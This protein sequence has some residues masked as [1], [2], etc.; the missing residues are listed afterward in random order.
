MRKLALLC[1]F[2][3]MP[4]LLA[5]AQERQIPLVAVLELAGEGVS[6]DELGMV[7]NLL[8]YAIADTLMVEAVGGSQLERL[9][10]EASDALRNCRDLSCAPEVGRLAG[11]DF[12]VAGMLRRVEKQVAFELNTLEVASAEVRV[13]YS[14]LHADVEEIID[15]IDPIAL[16]LARKLTGQQYPAAALLEKRDLAL[17]KVVC[18]T[19]GAR[20]HVDGE[21]AGSII[22]G[23]LCTLVARDR[24]ITVMVSMRGM[25]TYREKLT[26]DRSEVTVQADL[27]KMVVKR[28][29]LDAVFGGGSMGSL[30]V[31]VFP[32][33]ARWFITT[34]MGFTVCCAD[35]LLL[36]IPVSLRTGL[37]LSPDRPTRLHFYTGLEAIFTLIRVLERQIWIDTDAILT[38]RMNIGFMIGVEYQ[39][40]GPIRTAFEVSVF[41]YG[42]FGAPEEGSAVQLGI[43]LR[44]M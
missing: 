21:K 8:N 14:K 44:L 38:D 32:I 31:S 35:P 29:A 27:E 4:S 39:L 2:I 1:L 42:I 18:A 43:V 33:L 12:V 34:G 11:A 3:L 6:Q 36:N 22:Q 5:M 10:A 13:A 15:N 16:G 25:Y 17:L 24:E 20:V 37:Y 19:E 40:S 26:T 9:L 23:E 7:E 28:F 30:R 41:P